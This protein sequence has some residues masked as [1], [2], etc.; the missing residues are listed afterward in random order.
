MFHTWHGSVTSHPQSESVAE[1]PLLSPLLNLHVLLVDDE[2]VIRRLGEKFLKKLGCTFVTLTD[3]SEI[4]GVI[5][6]EKPPFD[7]II[8]DIVMA[9]TDGGAVCQRLRST[10]KVRCF[11]IVLSSS[12]SSRVRVIV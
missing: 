10:F 9:H 11:A 8:L 2:T 1:I 4:D 7:V 5:G 3:G 12:S 6:P